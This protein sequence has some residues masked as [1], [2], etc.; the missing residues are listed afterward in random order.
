MATR[1]E[2][3]LLADALL[4]GHRRGRKVAREYPWLTRQQ[5]ARRR[6]KEPL[7]KRDISVYA[8]LLSA[9]PGLR[10]TRAGR[11]RQAS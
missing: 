1:R 8:D 2:L 10:R 4:D 6:R 3:G 9:T 7:L 5:W 11:R